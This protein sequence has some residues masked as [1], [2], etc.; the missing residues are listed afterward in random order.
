FNEAWRIQRDWFYDPNLH[1]VDWEAVGAA[2]R[3]FVPYCGNRADLNYLIGEMIA[4]LNIGHTYVWG[5]DVSYGGRSVPTGL[6]GADLAIEPGV[7]YYRIKRI[8]PG[9]P[10]DPG[11][12]SP[13]D[14]PGC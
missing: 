14:E 6:L 13:L 12:R 5:G 10:G 8:I 3:K 7:K 9:T 11:E 1:G 4:E 2:Y